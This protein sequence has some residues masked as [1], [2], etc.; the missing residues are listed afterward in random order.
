MTKF[1]FSFPSYVPI[2]CQE[3]RKFKYH[4]KNSSFRALKQ[5]QL[6]YVRIHDSPLKM[7]N[8]VWKV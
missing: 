6:I 7:E 5:I 8:E 1:L 4:F 3:N 2:V